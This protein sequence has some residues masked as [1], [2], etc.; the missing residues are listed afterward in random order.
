MIIIHEMII[1]A[2]YNCDPFASASHNS[3]TNNTVQV[4]KA[5]N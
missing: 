1:P 2:F 4:I 5:E 3:E